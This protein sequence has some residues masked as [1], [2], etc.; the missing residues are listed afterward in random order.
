[1]LIVLGLVITVLITPGWRRRGLV[2]A[3]ALPLTAAGYLMLGLTGF[4]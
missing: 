1:V 3:L 2:L 4:R